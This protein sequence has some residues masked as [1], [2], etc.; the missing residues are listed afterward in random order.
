MDKW[1]HEQCFWGEDA[2]ILT[3]YD[4]VKTPYWTLRNKCF[5]RQRMYERTKRDE[6]TQEAFFQH[7]QMW[8]KTQFWSTLLNTCAVC[9]LSF[10]SVCGV[11]FHAWVF[12]CTL[13]E[14]NKV[15]PVGAR[16]SLSTEWWPFEAFLASIT[17]I[18]HARTLRRSKETKERKNE[19]HQFHLFS[20]VSIVVGHEKQKRREMKLF[21][22]YESYVGSTHWMDQK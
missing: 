10:V 7:C 9:C 2:S 5:P 6:T 3:K 17:H 11:S 19:K 13:L 12:S 8:R 18:T 16:Q 21:I 14:R 22:F 1:Y 15:N 4:R 20:S